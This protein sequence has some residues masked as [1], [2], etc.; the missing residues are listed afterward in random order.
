M[1]CSVF[2]DRFGS[3]AIAGIDLPSGSTEPVNRQRFMRR[4]QAVPAVPLSN[5]AYQLTGDIHAPG[6]SFVRDARNM[7]IGTE[8]ASL[9]LSLSLSV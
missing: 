8:I 2:G 3:P 9:S 7:N 6:G 1:P 4:T 5:P